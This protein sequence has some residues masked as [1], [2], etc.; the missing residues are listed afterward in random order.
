MDPLV[1][2]KQ[3]KKDKSF[4]TWNV[5]KSL[6]TVAREIARYKFD[7]V[8]VQEVRWDKRG[9]IRAEDN[10]FFYRR[11]NEYH[12]LWKGFFVHHRIVSTVKTVQFV[13]NT[14][15]LQRTESCLRS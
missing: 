10:F 2:S 6:A 14:Y 4:R 8:C 15:L 7:S 12:Q 5:R 11:G 13:S 3:L 9:T 1:N